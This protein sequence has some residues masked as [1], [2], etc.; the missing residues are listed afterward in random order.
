M[1]R[2][3]KYHNGSIYVTGGVVEIYP[4]AKPAE[5]YDIGD[6][7]QG[8]IETLKKDPEKI[9]AKMKTAKKIK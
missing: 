4:Q 3:L 8:E 5:E 9:K 6:L 7:T 1:K 2:I